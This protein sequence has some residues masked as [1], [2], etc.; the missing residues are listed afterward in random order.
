MHLEYKAN[1]KNTT[2]REEKQ[3]ENKLKKVYFFS[4]K[5]I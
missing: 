5:S 1:K 4:Y 2:K 3:N